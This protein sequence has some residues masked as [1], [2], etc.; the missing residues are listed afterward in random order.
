M[1]DLHTHTP[2]LGPVPRELDLTNKELAKDVLICQ[3]IY[4]KILES[5][6]NST[7]QMFIK[8]CLPNIL[9]PNPKD[10][11]F[12]ISGIFNATP[13]RMILLHLE[14][15]PHGNQFLHQKGTNALNDI[16]LI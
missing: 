13:G 5:T 4:N 10:I 9:L 7:L 16:T 11:F 8:R 2:L 12:K 1:G 15:M 14:G 3:L 6:K